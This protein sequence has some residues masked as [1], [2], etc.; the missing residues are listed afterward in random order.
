MIRII[1][2][3]ASLVIGTVAVQAA[4]H[5]SPGKQLAETVFQSAL[6]DGRTEA[7]IADM[8][9]FRDTIFVSVDS[10][11]DG[12]LTLQEF[13]NWDFGFDS[14]ANDKGDLRAVDVAR[15]IVFA[16]WD[17]NQD[18]KISQEEHRRSIIADFSATDVD[19]NGLISEEEFLTRFPMNIAMKAALN[20]PV[21]D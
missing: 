16:F 3:L 19:G 9:G 13:L 2:I 6:Q 7:T 4:D 10:D 20:T 5:K 1:G 17:L 12:N 14:I 8:E 21:R 18:G 15:A 11:D